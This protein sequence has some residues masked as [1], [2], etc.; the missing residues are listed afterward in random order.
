MCLANKDCPVDKRRRNRCQFCRFQKCLAVGMVKEGK[1]ILDFMSLL[2]VIYD[3]DKSHFAMRVLGSQ[4]Q[5]AEACRTRFTVPAAVKEKTENNTALVLFKEAST[6]WSTT[7]SSCLS[8]SCPH[9]QPQRSQG[10]PALQA[11]NSD[12]GFIHELQCQHYCLSCKGPFRLQSERRKAQL[13]Q[14]KRQYC[15]LTYQSKQVL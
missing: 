4:G 3:K 11:K 15:F 6:T 5:E 14:G 1:A 8:D 13:L 12:W 7:C 9:R 10:S 2:L